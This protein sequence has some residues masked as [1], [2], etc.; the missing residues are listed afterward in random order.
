MEFKVDVTDRLD[1]FLSSKLPDMSRTKLTAWMESEGVRVDGKE[2]KSSFKVEPGMVVTIDDIEPTPIHDLTPSD[3]PLDIIF[4]DD[5]FLIL[6]K[7]RGVASHPA[8]GL[9][10]P[11]LVNAL[12]GR[13]LNL[14]EGSEPYRPGIVH[15]LDKETTGLMVIA[16]TDHAHANL[17][18]QIA[19]KR[20]ERRYIGMARGEVQHKALRINAP[21]D[22]DGKD[23]R[24]MCVNPKGKSAATSI[25]VIDFLNGCTYFGARLETGRTHQIR[26]HML[27]IGHP[28]VG[29]RI[30]ATG[31]WAEGPMQLHAAYLAISHPET[32]ERLEFI[33]LPPDDFT[34]KDR[35]DPM[36]VKEWGAILTE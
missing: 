32:N 10:E 28:I 27:A 12:L 33:A 7:A 13:N 23:R 15:R 25:K 31:S 30:Y 29:D 2:R 8:P 14:S 17:S 9:N 16:K 1:K 22:R 4:E 24:K 11:T 19:L 3:M 18:Q 5:S 36:T 21:I 35:F 34:A 20:A 6:N 26:V